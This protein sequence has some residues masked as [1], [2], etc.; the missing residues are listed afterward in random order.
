MKFVPLLLLAAVLSVGCVK[1]PATITNLPTGVTSVQVVNWQTAVNQLQI[2]SDAS[3]TITT[4]VIALNKAGTLP[5]GPTYQT[6][7]RSVGRII[8][9]E[10]AA[11]KVLQAAPQQFGKTTGQQIT[12]Y[13]QSV[14]TE[15]ANLNATSGF[16]ITDPTKATQITSLIGSITSAANFV[17][18]LTGGL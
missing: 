7:L 16:G 6:V 11:N 12:G 15:V 3:H 13:L 10:Q 14:M 9:A 1:Q 18:S 2:I 5:D 4:T 17:L 8:L